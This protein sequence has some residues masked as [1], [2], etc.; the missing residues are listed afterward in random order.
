[1][2]AISKILIGVVAVIVLATVAVEAYGRWANDRFYRSAPLAAGLQGNMKDQFRGRIRDHFPVGSS[3]RELINVLT[4]QGFHATRGPETAVA[5]GSSEKPGMMQLT[6]MG[7]L[8]SDIC[9]RDWYVEWQADVD[10]RIAAID[11]SFF[12]TCP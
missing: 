11:A 2:K 10:G 8:I 5:D 7:D 1:L 4:S 3:E 6:K 9:R 12:F